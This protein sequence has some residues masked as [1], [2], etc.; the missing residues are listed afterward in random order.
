MIQ[1]G[2]SIKAIEL[3][4][5]LVVSLVASYAL[6]GTSVRFLIPFSALALLGV[7]TVI[8]LPMGTIFFGAGAVIM[9]LP[10]LMKV[11]GTEWGVFSLDRLDFC[12]TLGLPATTAIG[13]LIVTGTLFLGYLQPMQRELRTFEKRQADLEETRSYTRNQLRAMGAAIL[14]SAAIAILLTLIIAVV[15]GTLAG[16]LSKWLWAVPAGGFALLILLASGLFW[17]VS[18][19]KKNM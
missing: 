5:I 16:W 19:R 17:L 14:A 4:I 6:L 3:L 7:L 8:V 2:L 12:P 15:R 9:T 1:R 10:A 18:L 13:L 11:N